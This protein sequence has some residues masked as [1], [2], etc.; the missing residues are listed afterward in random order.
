M[1]ITRINKDNANDYIGKQVEVE[2]C[3]Y[4]FGMMYPDDNYLESFDGETW[5]FKSEDTE[6]GTW[7]WK[8]K[9]KDCEI[10][11]YDYEE[12]QKAYESA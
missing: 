9:D 10:T 11:V 6:N 8:Q 7:D 3:C 1:E 4:A 2:I 5:V 12:Y